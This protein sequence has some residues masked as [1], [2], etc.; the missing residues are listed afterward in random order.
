VK[1]RAGERLA[2]PALPGVPARLLDVAPTRLA[3]AGARP[4][5]GFAGRDLAGDLAR[6]PDADR[7]GFAEENGLRA[8]RTERWKWIE[9]GAA[10]PR[11]LPERALFDLAADP[12]ETSNVAERE[13]G[14]WA[15][16]R[17]RALALGAKGRR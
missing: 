13:P 1:W 10:D 2:P 17:R 6:R 15:E 12:R 3:R 9:A 14:T 5:A 8:V 11:G 16:L 7:I 4:P